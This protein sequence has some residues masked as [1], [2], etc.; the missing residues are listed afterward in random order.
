MRREFVPPV[1]YPAMKLITWNCNM[2]FRK[3][4]ERV[5]QH[6]PDVVVVQEC[7]NPDEKGDWDEF[8]DW[9]WIGESEHKGLGVCSRNEIT[10]EPALSSHCS[11]TTCAGVRPFSA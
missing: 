2:V 1:N 6:N 4:K 3:K 11:R 8:F 10:V 7:E 9:A 5:L